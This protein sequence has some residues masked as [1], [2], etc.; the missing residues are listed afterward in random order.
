MSSIDNEEKEATPTGTNGHSSPLDDKNQLQHEQLNGHLSS[1][2]PM[3]GVSDN[4]GSDADE[5][6][7]FLVN[8]MTLLKTFL[9]MTE[10]PGL[11]YK[12]GFIS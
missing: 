12:S 8:F 5:E 10:C 1:D 3:N 7:R 6:S 2:V 9:V 11:S 4:G